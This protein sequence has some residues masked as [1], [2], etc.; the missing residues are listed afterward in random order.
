MRL[1]DRLRPFRNCDPISLSAAEHHH[2]PR[3]STSVAVRGQTPIKPIDT[4]PGYEILHRDTVRFQP[5]EVPGLRAGRPMG[6]MSDCLGRFGLDAASPSF[7]GYG[8]YPPALV[9]AAAK[10]AA[11]AAGRELLSPMTRS[12][13][14]AMTGDR[15]FVWRLSGEPGLVAK[16]RATDWEDTVRMWN[17][18]LNVASTLKPPPGLS[19]PRVHFSGETP[20][21]WCVMD[22]AEGTPTLLT[23]MEAADV[24]SLV[25]AIQRTQL[26]GFRFRGAWDAATY[27]RQVEQPLAELVTAEVITDVTGRRVREVLAAHRPFLKDCRPV[28][29]HND[30]ALYHVF[31]GGR[32]T[33]IIDWE[34]V[35]HERLQMLD[36]SNLIVNHGLSRP[37]WACEL[38]RIALD[39]ARRDT[40]GD[41]GSNLVVAMLE[42]ALGKALDHLRRRH[43]QSVPAVDALCAVLEGQ[44][45]P[46]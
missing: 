5:Q 21:P 28:L 34:S 18:L 37:K 40:G 38:G 3:S 24:F 16:V 31:G 27:V 42:R 29:A 22:A 17:R 44:F 14:E 46:A 4:R 20:V 45:L 19:V 6:V 25:L 35:V 2:L 30:L 36:V 10:T 12:P 41:L 7:A 39:H 33:W 9:E 15:S 11:K 32:T 23:G 43:M 13:W 8:L 26:D 1:T